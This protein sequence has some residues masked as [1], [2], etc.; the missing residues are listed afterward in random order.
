VL[1]S[2]Q[3][4]TMLPKTHSSG[5]FSVELHGTR[6]FEEECSEPLDC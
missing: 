4:R 3:L 6:S 5:K 1:F 2:K